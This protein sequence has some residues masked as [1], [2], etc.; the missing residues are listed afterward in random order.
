MK[1]IAENI[2]RNF[3]RQ[4][5]GSNVLEALHPT[6]LQL[7]PGALTMVTGR[8]GSGKSTLLQVLA[9][10]LPPTTGK[11]TAD[12]QD[13]YRLPDAEQARFRNLHL[14]VVPQQAVALRS[15]T[16]RENIVLPFTLYGDA[17]EEARLTQLLDA[18]DMAKLVD[19]RPQEL[20]GGELRRVT[21][22]RALLR[23]PEV[24]LADEPT[25]DLDDANT[26]AVLELLKQEAARGAAVL[27][28]THEQAAA[29][30]ADVAYR[31]EAGVLYGN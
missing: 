11:V 6:D 14:G 25:G 2:S 16:V 15:L 30:Y 12:G 3:I 23:R 18:L 20:S 22:A 28:V 7:E 4:G 27:L 17:W 9:G 26:A 5:A 31:M 10:L 13:L 1:L 24:L 8:S 19:A 21:L 29:A